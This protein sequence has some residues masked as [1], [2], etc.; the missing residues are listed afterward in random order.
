MKT[1]NKLLIGLFIM[2]LFTLIGANVALK[3]KHD[4][5]DFN[6]PF[7]GLES[8]PLQPFRVLKLEGDNAGLVSVQT[9][10]RHE[11]RLPDQARAQFTFRYQGDTLLVNYIP[12]SIPWQSRANMYLDAIPAAVILTPTLQTVMTNRI[13]CNVNHFESNNLAVVQKSGGVLLTNSTIGT[14]T[15]TDTQGSDLHIK[16]TTHINTAVIVSRDSSGFMAERDVFGTLRLQ[17]DSLAT[18][19]VPGSLL[20]KLNP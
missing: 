7:Y 12:S 5:I 2:G 19:K 4:K 14:L 3:V 15:V 9:G 18:V 13:S 11:I 10:Q 17:T 8:I 1:S 6:D 20:K 16:P